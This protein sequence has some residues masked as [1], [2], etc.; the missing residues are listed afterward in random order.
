MLLLLQERGGRDRGASDGLLHFRMLV[1][2]KKAGCVIGK[3]HTT[4]LG[5]P[6]G[7]QQLQLTLHTATAVCP[8]SEAAQQQLMIP[9]ILPMSNLFGEHFCKAKFIGIAELQSY[10]RA[11]LADVLHCCWCNTFLQMAYTAVGESLRFPLCLFA[12]RS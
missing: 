9:M 1:P 12:C 4:D 11:L 7:I 8:A 3:V 2:V 5:L 6:A 10:D